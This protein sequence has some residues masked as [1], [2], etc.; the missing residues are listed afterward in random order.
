MIKFRAIVCLALSCLLTLS[1]TAQKKSDSASHP[2]VDAGNGCLL[3]GVVKGK[4]MEDAAIAPL[5]KGGERYRLYTLKGPA[6]EVVGTQP[7]EGETPCN[8][9]QEIKLSP[10]A[11]EGFAVRGAWNAMPRVPQMLSVNDPV[12][13]QVVNSILRRH[14]LAKSKVN[15]TQV[16]KID[17]DGDG[18]DEVLI[19][20]SYLAGGLNRQDAPMAVRV[21]RGDY[22]F[23][24]LRKVVGGKVRDIELKGEYFPKKS[25][26]TATQYAVNGVLDLNGDGKMEVVLSVDYYEGSS[27][28]VF[29]INGARVDNVFGCGCGV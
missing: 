26:A 27:S 15:I 14:G 19:S 3:G 1:A 6:G 12:Y 24:S 8:G 13:R 17:L 10:D 21:K 25:D 2:A 5:L 20:A 23:V 11:N 29:R 4:W 28:T 9:A 7:K 16:L 18:V 22:S